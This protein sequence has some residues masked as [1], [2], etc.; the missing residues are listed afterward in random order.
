MPSLCKCR[1]FRIVKLETTNEFV[2]VNT[3]TTENRL[4]IIFNINL[5]L[6]LILFLCVWY[7]I[8]YKNNNNKKK[9]QFI[10]KIHC[11][12][13][14]MKKKMGQ[15]RF[16]PEPPWWQSR[17]LST[18]LPALLVSQIILGYIF[19][20]TN[21]LYDWI[22]QMVQTRNLNYKFC[23]DLSYWENKLLWQVTR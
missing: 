9:R 12:I 2:K 15:P 10:N 16:E 21:Y 13:K 11:K 18:T 23:C 19:L 14:S 17:I 20:F 5:I 1:I 6:I 8:D 22:I 4:K 7:T 3:G